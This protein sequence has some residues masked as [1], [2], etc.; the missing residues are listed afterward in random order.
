MEVGILTQC[1][2]VK[3]LLKINDGN[4]RILKSLLF[5]INTKLNGIN[6]KFYKLPACLDENVPCMV[7]GANVT[8]PSQDF[9]VLPSI[10]AITASRNNSFFQY[11][12][13]LQL[14]QP[15]QE[16]ILDLEKI[17]PMHLE[18]YYQEMKQ[19][20]KRIF[21]YRDGV[22]ET[23]FPQ[24]ICHEIE[25]IKKAVF[26]V[27]RDENIEITC[28]IVQKSHNV[29]LSHKSTNISDTEDTR[30]YNVKPGTIVDTTNPPHPEYIDFYL[31]SHASTDAKGIA[32]PTRYTC[33]LNESNF[34]KNQI[35]ELTFYLCHMYGRFPK[36]VSYPIPT[37][38]ADL[39]AYRGRVILIQAIREK[40]N[41]DFRLSDFEK[42][43]KNF[44]AN[45]KDHP[46]FYI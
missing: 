33:I 1:M 35:E 30:N 6:H 39:A 42:E 32:K 16:K 36:A 4:Q 2:K 23:E 14:Q 19:F 29:H 41:T 15:Y 10:A 34:T 9:K 37:Y 20:P 38:Y 8:H 5:E 28:L 21:Y 24:V 17:I 45:M 40:K 25:P 18:A 13:A 12:V 7:I 31:V 26:T 43:W 44:I 3:T 22:G 27:T 46:M 11:N